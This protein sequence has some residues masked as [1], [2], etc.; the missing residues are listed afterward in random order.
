M[1]NLYQIEPYREAREDA[2]AKAPGD[3]VRILDGMGFRRLQLDRRPARSRAVSW[4]GWIG[5]VAKCVWMFGRLPRGSVVFFQLPSAMSDGRVHALFRLVKQ[6]RRLRLVA[7]FHDICEIQHADA[8]DR[9]LSKNTQSVIALADRIIV[10]NEKMIAWL[11][12]KGVSREKMVSLG[13]FDYLCD[14]SMADK[15]RERTAPVI[16]AGRLGVFKSA[17][18]AFLG[19]L[20]DIHFNLYGICGNDAFL[21][22]L[23]VTYKG[24]FSP[25]ELPARLEGGWGLV[26]DG[27]SIETC[28]NGPGHYLKYNNPHKASLYL[29]AGIPL[30]VWSG[31]ALADFVRTKGVGLTIDSLRDLRKIIDGVSE[32]QYQSMCANA[33]AQAKL[34]RAGCYSRKAVENAK[35]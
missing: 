31:S 8:A 1:T 27:D 32:A 26:W 33:C 13:L 30:I 14:V 28:G 25:D 24:K 5:W 18:L 4:I 2:F 35:D 7:L 12:T 20:K 3:V 6:W 21:K 17:Y 23:N 29:C 22:N 16:I 11:E 9:P 19:E 15:K 10:H 34:L